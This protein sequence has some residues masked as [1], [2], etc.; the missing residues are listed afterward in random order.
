MV[1]RSTTIVAAG[2]TKADATR[3]KLTPEQGFPTNGILSNEY[4]FK[5]AAKTVSYELNVDLTGGNYSY[6]EDTVL[7]MAVHGG[8]AMHHTDQNTLSKI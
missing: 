8:A 3:F 4:L 1:P 7:E 5:E 6:K 2:S